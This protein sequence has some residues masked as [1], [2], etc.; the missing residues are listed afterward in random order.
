MILSAVIF[1][2]VLV[3]AGVVVD[4][5]MAYVDN[6]E[7]QKTA[8]AAAFAASSLLPI[9]VSTTDGL[10]KQA[11][12]EALAREYLAKN[13]SGE[14]VFV[15][16]D[17][18]DSFTDDTDGELYTSVRVS[19][20]RPVQYLFGPIVGI[21]GTTLTRHAKVRIEAVIGGVG[22]AP[23]G[24]SKVRRDATPAGESVAITFDTHDEEVLNGNFGSLDL[25]GGGGGASEFE[26][27]YVNGFFGDIILNDPDQP[28]ESQTGVIFGKAKSG[29]D[30]RYNKCT[31]FP[32]QGGCTVDHFV[33]GC[34]RVIVIV[35]HQR[36]TDKPPHLYMPMGFSPYILDRLD[37]KALYVYP[38]TLR[39]KTGKSVPLTDFNYDFGLFRTRLVE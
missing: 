4:L 21:D 25:N 15:G 27:H 3:M 17:F 26:D 34:P 28:L 11:Q 7:L 35:I 20:Q 22:I 12:A 31:H 9:Q 13:D 6:S 32:D 39:V 36:V 19:L 14:A 23:L 16:I 10:A 18:G 30:E 33:S 24:I 8:D 29:F 1:T 5:G 2:S 38:I 37:N